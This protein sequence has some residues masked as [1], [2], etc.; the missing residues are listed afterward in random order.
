MRPFE[1]HPVVRVDWDASLPREQQGKAKERTSLQQF[2]RS[3]SEQGRKYEQQSE[4]C[5][6]KLLGNR[7]RN[8]NVG[9]VFTLTTRASRRRT[10]RTVTATSVEQ[11]IALSALELCGIHAVPSLRGVYLRLLH[12]TVMGLSKPLMCSQIGHLLP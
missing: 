10:W 5:V 9:I 3:I 7:A 1:R 6:A 8:L 2:C 12:C 4:M 11:M